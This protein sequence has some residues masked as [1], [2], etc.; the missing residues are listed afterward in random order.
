ME[1]LQIIDILE[2]KIEQ[3]KSIPLLNRAL[4]DREDI[5]ANIEEIRINLP[6]DMKQARLI[7][8]ERKRIIAEA[9][10]EAD[11]II[12]N[13]KIKTEEM[14]NE[15]EITKKAYEQANQIIAAAQKNS[16]ELRMG[17]RQYVDSLFADTDAKLTKAQSIIRKARA[18]VRQEASKPALEQDTKAE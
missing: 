18:D 11:E 3:S 16:R 4:I 17:A 5:L 9:Q 8:D 10:A 13:A 15:H 2:D 7:K 1:I 6:D 12:K 14:V